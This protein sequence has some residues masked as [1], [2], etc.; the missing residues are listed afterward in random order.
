MS[1]TRRLGPWVRSLSGTGAPK[2]GPPGTYYNSQLGAWIRKSGEAGIRIHDVSLAAVHAQEFASRGALLLPKLQSIRP[3][4]ID[5]GSV[6]GP[7][8]ARI[9]AVGPIFSHAEKER[10]SLEAS[11]PA[12]PGAST[13]LSVYTPDAKTLEEWINVRVIAAGNKMVTIQESCRCEDKTQAIKGIT[14]LSALARAAC[15]QVKVRL[16]DAFSGGDEASFALQDLVLGISDAG[17]SLLYR[18]TEKKRRM[19]CVTILK[20]SWG[21]MCQ[22]SR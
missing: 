22:G 6:L 2:T 16:V 9:C 18:G 5:L 12:G 17:A 14:D 13:L 8:R 7:S 20:R 10:V 11:L 1:A 19:M 21:W 15:I 4:S 3:A